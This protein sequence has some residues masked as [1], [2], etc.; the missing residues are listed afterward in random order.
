MSLTDQE[1]IELE[2][3][4]AERDRDNR[5]KSL[6]EIN[7]ETN[8][9]YKILYESLNGQVWGKDE[10]NKPILTSGVVGCALE[11]SSRS[12]KTWG[13]IFFIYYLT[14]IRHAKDGCTIN[15]YRETYNEFKTTIYEDFKRTLPMFGLPNKF[16]TTNEV[17]MFRIGKSVINLL[18]DGKHGGGCDYAFFNESM[19]IK[20][21]V[22]NQVEMR[23]RIFWWMD[24]KPSLSSH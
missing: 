3:L 20:Q 24:D 19:K 14:L 18:G 21:S 2:R 9:N 23:C 6:T 13:G 12:Q 11:G 4:V 8:P 10:N 22:F 16:E 5:L 7:D 15:I 1:L 17:S